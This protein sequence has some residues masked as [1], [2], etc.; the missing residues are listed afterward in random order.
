M[1]DGIVQRDAKKIF[2][3][4]KEKNNIHYIREGHIYLDVKTAEKQ[5]AKSFSRSDDTIPRKFK[6]TQ[7]HYDILNSKTVLFT[8]TGVIENDVKSADT[9]PWVIA[10]TILWLKEDSV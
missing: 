5:Y 10:Y 1:V 8:G 4:F 9:K 3:I 7:K 2:S 6:F